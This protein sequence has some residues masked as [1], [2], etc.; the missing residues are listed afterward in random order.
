MQCVRIDAPRPLA[1]RRDA[2][3]LACTHARTTRAGRHVTWRY[4]EKPSV[5]RVKPR[6]RPDVYGNGARLPLYGNGYESAHGRSNHCD[7]LALLWPPVCLSAYPPRNVAVKK[8][9]S[10]TPCLVKL[11]AYSA[12]ARNA[13]RC[14]V[15]TRCAK[16]RA[17]LP[18]DQD[19]VMKSPRM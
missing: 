2:R 6:A 17:P 14:P 13:V 19:D 11:D 16:T 1:V 10:L 5:A 4:C 18:R 3:T 15:E 8:A 12:Y 7:Q 9:A